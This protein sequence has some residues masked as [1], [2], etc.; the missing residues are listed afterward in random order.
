[1]AN[2]PTI[3]L[4]KRPHF[5]PAVIAA[6]LL[7][8]ALADWPYGYYQFLR[9]VVCGVGIYMAVTVYQWRKMWAI[10]LFGIAAVLFNPFAPIHL[11]KDLWQ[12]IDV[13]CAVLFLA[14]AFL[15]R[16][17]ANHECSSLAHRNRAG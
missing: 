4:S 10:W 2:L 13:G 8:L 11:S 9:L 16:P 1:M 6:L 14:G 15:L 17:E 5:I 3:S 7:L 12:P